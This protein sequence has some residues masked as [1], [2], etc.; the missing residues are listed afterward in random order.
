[1]SGTVSDRTEPDMYRIRVAGYRVWSRATP[2]IWTEV[3]KGVP[4]PFSMNEEGKVWVFRISFGVP[5]CVF[6]EL[7]QKT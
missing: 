6:N 2:N 4:Q 5:S 3:D 1:M 7:L